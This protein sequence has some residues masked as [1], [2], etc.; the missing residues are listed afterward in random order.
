M[1]APRPRPFGWDL[2]VRAVRFFYLL[3]G[4]MLLSTLAFYGR[5]RLPAAF[6]HWPG[7]CRVVV[8]PWGRALALGL[9]L[10]MCLAALAEVWELVDRL[11]VRV[12]GDADH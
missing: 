8:G 6:W 5:L 2:L 3:W 7:L 4:G 12:M 10:V 9:G 1:P 11:L